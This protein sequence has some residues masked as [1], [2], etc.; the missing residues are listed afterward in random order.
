MMLINWLIVGGV[1]GFG[2][3]SVLVWWL[4]KK[5]SYRFLFRVWSKD[6]SSSRVVKA[7]ITI[8]KQ[9]KNL[10]MFTFEH[11][12][13]S[14]VMRDPQH[15]TNG[16]PERWV[17]PDE[18]GEYQYLSPN[19]NSPID[20]TRYM[21]TRLHPVNRQ[22]A[23]EQFRNNQNRYEPASNSA[24]ITAVGMIILAI[25]IAIGSLY[26]MINLVR[27]GE[28]IND[29]VHTMKGLQDGF[30]SV[31]LDFTNVMEITTGNLAFIYGQIG[32]NSTVIRP[33]T[34]FQP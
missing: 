8:N 9:N 7:R 5:K 11:N 12:P 6:L 28:T 32:G 26:G 19:P 18:S 30:G 2:L 14:L 31:M 20:K 23:L 27:Y 16:K 13:S 10:R 33:V 3:I 15:T 1:V 4:N 29:N 17:T 21:Q 25:I 24:F 22:L 34:G